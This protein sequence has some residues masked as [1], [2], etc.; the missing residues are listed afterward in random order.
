MTNC[1]VCGSIDY[2]NCGHYFATP[3]C[4]QCD[5]NDNCNSEM[6]AACVLY[7]PTYPGQ[8]T[9][10]SN[11]VNLALPN[12]SSAQTIFDA[13]DAKLGT[14]GAQGIVPVQ[15]GNVLLTVSG[16]NNRSL[17]ADVVPSPNSGNLVT[18][19]SN[20]VYVANPNPN[21]LVKVDAGSAPDYLFNQ[22]TGETNGCVSINVLDNSG[23]VVLQPV[24]DITCFATT[25][26]A[27]GS[28]LKNQIANCLLTTGLATADTSTL[29][30][31][32]SGATPNVLT[33]AVKVSATG[34][35][36]ITVNSDGLYVASSGGT[37]TGADNGLSLSGTTVELGGAL[38]KATNITFATGAHTLQF[39]S[40]PQISI[41][42]S[43]PSGG[44]ILQ[45]DNTYASG[46][47]KTAGLAT[48]TTTNLRA[49]GG[50]VA[51]FSDLILTGGTDTDTSVKAG[52][53][54]QIF[55]S[56]SGALNTAD[57]EV[58]YAGV[59]GIVVPEGSGTTITGAVVVGGVIGGAFASDNA[60]I[61]SIAALQ[62]RAV[63]QSPGGSAYSGTITNYYGL[64][65]EDNSTGLGSHITNKYAIFQEGST[66]LN[67]FSTAV[68]VTSDERVKTN[69]ESYTRGLEEIEKLETVKFHFK[70]N[71]HAAKRV[72]VIAQ[73][74]EKVIPEA[75][76]TEK[77]YQHNIDDFRKLDTDT[78]IF[79]LINAVKELSAKVKALE[80]K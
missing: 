38:T 76:S 36:A 4:D 26:C 29:H 32:L 19:L 73:A 1:S 7:H 12:G 77:N 56:G 24:F 58:A 5:E 3:Y 57:A 52:S 28:G 69:I 79:T 14:I 66:M 78:I 68:V 53:Y 51:A 64:Y 40:T 74:I 9:P 2:I 48:T 72:G 33:G 62:A 43:A 47:N 31:A 42:E 23:Q 15:S 44:S 16:A 21:Y 17:R 45:I 60:T 49:S 41:G 55:F 37:V 30:L 8:T 27:Q 71:V 35:N 18:V 50:G 13:I 46:F 10:T 20:G 61:N 63:Y 39:S 80:A 65:I 59:H 67:S 75:V 54:G 22:M 6:D 70:D 34:G 25:L 11:L